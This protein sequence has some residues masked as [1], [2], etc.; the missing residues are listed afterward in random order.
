ML[1]QLQRYAEGFVTSVDCK[2]LFVR[3]SLKSI[4]AYEV[5]VIDFNGRII[6]GYCSETGMNV[7]LE[8]PVDHISASLI[9]V[10]IKNIRQY[11]P[12]SSVVALKVNSLIVI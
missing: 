2:N 5:Q 11:Y 10:K 1:C 4:T 7:N 12:E 6:S 8:V 9:L 3:L